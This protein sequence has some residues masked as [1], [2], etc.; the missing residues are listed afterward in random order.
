MRQLTLL[1]LL[2]PPLCS[3]SVGDISIAARARPPRPHWSWSKSLSYDIMIASA[4]P[5]S[6][7]TP[8]QLES[9]PRLPL[10]TDDQDQS[11]LL[12]PIATESA[13]LDDHGA[14]IRDCLMPHITQFNG[15]W[16]AYGYG[17]PANATGDQRFDTCYTSTNLESWTKAF[18]NPSGAPLR[19]ADVPLYNQKNQEFVSFSENYGHS[20]A[21]FTSISPL[22][23]FRL[24]QALSPLF[25][26]PG[27]SS[28]FVD[29]D[30]TAF[31]IYNRYSG[32]IA[33]RFAYI[34]QLNDDYSDILPATLSNT[35]RVMEGL[36][37]IKCKETYFLFGS[38][39]VVYDDADDFYLTAPTP[40]GPWTY[41]GLFAPQGS[42]TFNSQ[43][44]RGL[45]VTGPK[46]TATVFIGTRWCNPYPARTPSPANT[47]PPTCVCHPPFR[48]ATSIWLPLVFNADDSVAELKWLDNWTLD[49][50]GAVRLKS[51]DATM[52]MTPSS[53]T[54][55]S[56]AQLVRDNILEQLIPQ[57]A[58][59]HVDHEVAALLHS[60]QTNGTWP[61]VDYADGAKDWWIAADHLRR[62]LLM[63][64][65]LSS[66]QSQHHSVPTLRAAADK[67]FEWWLKTNLQNH[68]WW[69][70][71]GV[72]RIVCKYLLMLPSPRLYKMAL[73]LLD[74]TSLSVAKGYTGC[75]R[76]WGASIH[77]LRGA[78]ELNST[79]LDAA[80]AVARSTLHLAIQSSDGI[81]RD[82]SFHQVSNV[83]C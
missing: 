16:Y 74:V 1:L 31:L 21:S 69:S 83:K 27:D 41:R 9:V 42:R 29:S 3:R 6:G 77:I 36:W 75:N 58:I 44:F 5:I 76:V 4:Q 7:R 80:F 30:G 13:M 66:Q 45:Q 65:A 22:G 70:A 39:L 62:C 72:P 52:T 68:W 51:D 34:Y 79:R 2:S 28:T 46:G 25:G 38:P 59:P 35:T 20:M 67:A 78:I 50:E 10:K 47:C 18:Q 26:N 11:S 63:A 60:L 56:D 19:W 37:M 23:P 73:P 40:L 71:I 17:I 8:S 33:Q 32:P 15:T 43:V 64:S 54:A 48:N 53:D 24:K 61:D 81:Q 82:G 12:V 49:T 57:R 14:P 55:G